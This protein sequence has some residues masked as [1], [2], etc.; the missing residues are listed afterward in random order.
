M[1]T[2]VGDFKEFAL[3]Y[4]SQHMMRGLAL[5]SV[6][7]PGFL[8][9]VLL[10]AVSVP[11]FWI[12][13]A[14]LGRAWATPEYS[15]GPLIPMISLYLFLRELRDKPPL[16]ADTT[17]NRWP[18]IAVI[19]LGT[20]IAIV[21]NMGSIPDV[22][23]YAYI[24]WVSGVVLLF[25]GWAEG[26]RHQLPVL[27]LIFMLPLPQYVYW[28]MTAFLQGVSSELGVMVIRMM[29]IPV[30]LDGNI[31]DLGPYQLLV[32]EACS[33]LRYLFPIMSFSYLMAILYRG[34]YWHKV[35][36]FAVAA[37]L[38]VAMN[39]FRI[40]VIGVLV[41]Y[42][43]IEQAEGFLH[44]FEGWVIF[45]ACI[46]LLF[47]LALIL[48]RSTLKSRPLSEVIDFDFGG[49]GGQAT[50]IFDVTP[51]RSYLGAGVLIT[52]LAMAL[53]VSP[54]SE[55][56]PPLRSDFVLYPKQLGTWVGTTFALDPQ[57]EV[58]LGADN[59]INS[60]F[61]SPTAEQPVQFFSAWYASQTE[62]E[63]IHSPQVCLPAG[64][65]EIFR[66]EK[67]E[68]TIPDT[69][70]GTFNVNRAIIERGF[71]QQL[72]YY[73]FE[74]RGKRLTND[75]AAKLSVLR[76]GITTGRTDGALVRFVTLIGADEDPRDADAR[77]QAFMAEALPD[78]P[79][80]IPE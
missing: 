75:V 24:I 32:A 56:L 71:E 1:F 16:P 64:G 77:I 7:K 57:V 51:A 20:V 73:W 38:T 41:N 55:P 43:G 80:F 17:M 68:I 74:Q 26:R 53:A 45:G 78:L 59:Y 62:G 14:A 22:V 37:P 76:D 48:Q 79:R 54:R 58:V 19:T 50:R 10:L 23:T 3:T 36:L 12:G 35:V 13:F 11:L 65:W 40:G 34:P 70:Y 27:H 52:A 39:S 28:K 8:G 47:L 60:V 31:I 30:F 33:G 67:E 25:M 18:G 49:L 9:F 63:G 44:F 46:A 4:S 15:H 69:V 2:F 66:L 29:D 21:G 6:L 72:V 5:K 42:R 61:T